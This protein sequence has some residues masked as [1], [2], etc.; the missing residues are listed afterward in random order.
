EGAAHSGARAGGPGGERVPPDHGRGLFLPQGSPAVDR[1][2]RPPARPLPRVR[3]HH[4][5]PDQRLPHPPARSPAGRRR[6]ALAHYSWLR[7]AGSRDPRGRPFLRHTDGRCLRGLRLG[8]AQGRRGR[9]RT[10]AQAGDPPPDEARPM[11]ETP[12]DELF[13]DYTQEALDSLPPELRAEMSNV[14][15]VVAQ[16]PPDS[17]P[18]LGLYED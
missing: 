12:P 9:P 2:A 1:R 6:V 10:P 17:Q 4:D 16:E 14:E 7:E 3:R 13:A 11:S 15:V 8:S 5:L 18:L